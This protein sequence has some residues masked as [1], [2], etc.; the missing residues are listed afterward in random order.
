MVREEL[1]ENNIKL[2]NKLSQDIV[3][4]MGSGGKWFIYTILSSG[5][6]VKNHT[7]VP[8]PILYYSSR[9]YSQTIENARQIGAEQFL[10]QVKPDY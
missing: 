3:I 1:K 5:S 8:T 4:N 7:R 10:L 2:Q 9:Q 6:F